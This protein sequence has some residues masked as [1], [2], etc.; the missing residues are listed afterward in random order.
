MSRTTVQ[1]HPSLIPSRMRRLIFL[2]ALSWLPLSSAAQDAPTSEPAAA[3]SSADA[4]RAIQEQGFKSGTSSVAR[5]GIDPDRYSSWTNHSNRL[6]PLYTF[7]FT[8]DALRAEGSAYASSERLRS[9]YG[10]VPEQTLNP[11][12]TYFDQTDVYRLQLAAHDAG[13]S[14]IILMVFDGMDWQTTRA[15]ALYQGGHYDSGRGSGL[16]IQ[17][18]RD[19]RTDFGYVVTSPLLGGAKTDVNA[20]TVV[21]TDERATG[22]YSPA[23]GGEFPW[24]ENTTNGYLLGLSRDLPHAVTDSAASATSMTSGVKTYNGAINFKADGS[25]TVPIARQLQSEQDFRV[26]VV[27]SVPVSHATPAAAYANNVA[28][29]DYQDIARDL[30]GLKSS[31]HRDQPLPGVDVL[32]GGGWGE[33]VKSDR[34]QGDN[35]QVGNK[36]LHQDDLRRSNAEHGGKYVVAQRTPGGSGGEQ[37]LA[38]AQY[39]AD[40]DLRLLGFYGVNGGHLPYRTADGDWNPTIDVTGDGER[41]APADIEENPT[42]AEMTRAALLVLEQSIDGF[43]LMIEAGDV[44]WANH[45]N[46]LDNSIG[47]VISGD[48]A[49][50]EVVNWVDENNAWDYTAIIVTADHGHFLVLDEPDRIS[51]PAATAVVP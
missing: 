9:L 21:T 49:F 23:R 26:G 15:A 18:F 29:K 12:A 11:S 46:N 10:R 27:T 31:S 3:A 35:F 50:R 24:H 48:E 4:M 37:L 43:W 19:V 39:A 40:E 22:G 33:D 36:Y 45:A 16:L 1:N 7:G 47:A 2:V 41:Y 17:D 38:A 6:V 8:L 25:R 42:L 51:P 13:Y 28:R 30:L 32:I 34:L 20:Q 14:N 44:D 5:W